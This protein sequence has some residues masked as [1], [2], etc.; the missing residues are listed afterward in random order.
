MKQ[1][2]TTRERSVLLLLA[3]GHNLLEISRMWHIEVTTVKTHSKSLYKKLGAL[4]AGHAV[5]LGVRAGY[6]KINR[7]Q[8]ECRRVHEAFLALYHQA[9]MARLNA[10]ATDP[11]VRIYFEC[12]REHLRA[13]ADH[14]LGHE[15]RFGDVVKMFGFPVCINDQLRRPRLV[16][17]PVRVG[18]NS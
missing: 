12:A 15:G 17:E 3:E 10:R 8:E 2:L 9:D 7:Y 11:P 16:I 1:A 4:N 5:V 13:I 14:S 6:I 18:E